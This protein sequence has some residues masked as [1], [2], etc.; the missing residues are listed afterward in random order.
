MQTDAFIQKVVREKFV[1]TTVITI[2]HRLNT[3][4]D[5]N[6]VVVMKKGKIVEQGSPLELLKKEGLFFEMVKH[7]GKN[8]E[9]I[10][11]K[12]LQH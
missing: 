12:A 9:L 3:I 4:A 5:Y 8:A 11:E 1:E 10:I 2:A 6:K 7:T